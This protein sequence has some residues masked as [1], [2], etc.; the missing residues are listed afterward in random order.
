[1]RKIFFRIISGGQT[2]V[3]RAALDA[4]TE[5][6]L[7]TGGW[8]PKGRRAEDGPIDK[9]Y[10][11]KETDSRN[12]AF[13]TEKNVLDSDGTLILTSG[14]PKGGTALTIKLARVHQKPLLIIDLSALKDFRSVRDWGKTHQIKILNVAGPRASESPGIHNE[15]ICFLKK[16]LQPF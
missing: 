7:E 10:P 14:S 13:R 4:A 2:G 8:C 12:Y 1:M 11:L 5:L 16:I 9:R 6:G 15:A 3:D